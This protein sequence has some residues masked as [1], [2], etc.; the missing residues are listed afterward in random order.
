MAF[1]ASQIEIEHH[2]YDP[3]IILGVDRVGF[4]IFI[5]Y[6]IVNKLIVNLNQGA[7]EKIIRKAYRD[8]SKVMHPDRGGD[9]EKFK[10][11]AKAY[12]AL[13]DEETRKAWEEYGNPDGP[14]G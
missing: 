7:T 12:K 3:Y 2:E 13:T 8:L 10:E 5:I 9:E 4:I 11:L 1:K 6:N 14:G